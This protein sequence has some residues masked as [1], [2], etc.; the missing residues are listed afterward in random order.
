MLHR[1]HDS[2]PHSG[3]N[4]ITEKWLRNRIRLEKSPEVRKNLQLR[5]RR[6]LLEQTEETKPVVKKATKKVGRPKK[7]KADEA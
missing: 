6:L 5:L 7:K 4:M 2:F 1:V 3:V